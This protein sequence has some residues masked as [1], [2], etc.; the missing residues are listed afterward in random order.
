M[1]IIRHRSRLKNTLRKLVQG[2]ELSVGFLGGSIT[3]ARPRH[4][5]PEAVIAWLVERYPGVSIRVEN[6]AIGATGSELAVYRA[7]RD[8]LQRKCDLVFVEYAVNDYYVPRERRAQT[9]EGLLRKLLADGTSDV[10]LTYT[11]NQ[12]MYE[13]MAN[14]K[15]PESISDFE[16]LAEHYGLGSVWMGL[17]AWQ[18]VAR[19]MMRWEE[20]LPDGLH[21]TSRGSLCYAQSVIGFLERELGAGGQTVDAACE[22]ERITLPVPLNP[23]NWENGWTLDLTRIRREG[24]WSL[25]RW[26]HLEWIDQCLVTS[27]IGSRLCFSFQGRGFTLGLDFGTLSADFRYRL[28]GEDWRSVELDRP[29]WCPEEG[30]FLAVTVADDLPAGEHLCEIEVVHGNRERCRGS[31]F[32][33]AFVGIISPGQ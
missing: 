7:E 1:E 12:D 28:N 24:P 14:R 17:H 26:P 15:T 22:A 9:R 4:N 5:W 19:G 20:W 11:Y 25:R 18:E 32:Q 2:G 33:L 30:W 13:D 10:V 21:P 6:A 29:D 27:A 23:G 31:R 8:I 3:D 16:Q